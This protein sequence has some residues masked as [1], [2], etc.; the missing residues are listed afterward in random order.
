M[1]ILCRTQICTDCLFVVNIAF[2][3]IEL[4]RCYSL[5][6]L[7]VYITNTL[8]CWKANVPR[9]IHSS[10]QNMAEAKEFSNSLLFLRVFRHRQGFLWVKTKVYLFGFPSLKCEVIW[11]L[12]PVVLTDSR[13]TRTWFSS[14]YVTLM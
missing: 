10:R 6:W 2:L 7:I 9:K 1:C 12:M 8:I 5:Q 14:P 13:K 4:N 11:F 3:K